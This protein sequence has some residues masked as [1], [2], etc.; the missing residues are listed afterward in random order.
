MY[1]SM[2]Y[3][4]F[5]SET[6]SIAEEVAGPPHLDNTGYMYIDHLVNYVY[7]YICTCYY[8]VHVHVYMLDIE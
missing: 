8:T 2:E 7:M 6:S 4:G 5:S 3:N 1:I